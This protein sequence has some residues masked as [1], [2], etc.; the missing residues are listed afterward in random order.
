[1]PTDLISLG[2][3]VVLFFA[4]SYLLS[5]AVNHY[6]LK[7]DYYGW[8]IRLY[9]ELRIDPFQEMGVK[10]YVKEMLYF[11]GWGF[12]FLLLILTLQ[13]W[14]PLNPEGFDGVPLPLAINITTS[15]VTNTNW[16]PYVPEAVLS[17]FSQTC[18]LTVQNF[19]S[20]GVGL[21]AFIVLVRGLKR[22]SVETLGSFR[23]DIVRAV[24]FLVPFSALF[25]L[26]LVWQGVPETLKPYQEIVTLEGDKQTIPLGMVASQVSI[27][28]LG[29]NGGGYF[30]ANSAHPFENPTPLSNLLETLSILI[31]PAALFLAWGQATGS[32]RH[33]WIL[34][35]ATFMLWFGFLLVALWGQNVPN[36]VIDQDPVLEG[37]ET[38][39]GV[40]DT[41]LWS[42]S[43]TATSN[44]SANGQLTSLSP[45]AGGVLLLNM[46]LG[47]VIYGGIGV[48]FGSFFIFILI[49]LFLSGLM[50]GRTPE[51]LGKKIE[52]QEMI[53]AMIAFMTPVAM[54]LLGST[55]S[56]VLFPEMT[57]G[58]HALTELL[59]AYTS[60]S[61]NNGSSMTGFD[62]SSTFFLLFFSL[63]MWIGRLSILL[64][65]VFLAWSFS[66]K[67][68]YH[69]F[70]SLPTNT[71]IFTALLMSV[72][73]IL[74][75]LTYFPALAL[76]PLAEQ[77][78]MVRGEAT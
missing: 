67:K 32:Q 76:G 10:R 12:L 41:L 58:P 71:F 36:R 75:A 15:F 55:L 74:G 7:E 66:S 44:G 8:E 29:S 23:V 59:Y 19:L 46:M 28:Q 26:I 73:L 34:F 38:R 49:T 39:I 65:M 69:S 27:K 21:Q 2:V 25:S 24:L 52:K 54:I 3:F 20:A 63:L 70:S 17:Y 53:L 11:Q 30:N 9:K 48:G 68:I 1:M 4:L 77:V 40:F 45:L 64:V 6:L 62:A 16:Q 56:L 13:G 72:I 61:A 78:L 50:V 33:G 47:E 37:I 42:V 57:Q 31:F 35:M 14:L 51:Y 22:S 18:G 5:L 43:T 60:T